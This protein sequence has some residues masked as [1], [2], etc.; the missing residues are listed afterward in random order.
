[1]TPG[2]SKQQVEVLR[3]IEDW[4]GRTTTMPQ[5]VAWR[6]ILDKMDHAYGGAGATNIPSN[7]W[8]KEQAVRR[9]L[10]SLENR[11]VVELR[12]YR[13]YWVDGR[14]VGNK[15]VQG[16]WHILDDDQYYYPGEDRTMIG[17]VLTEA[18]WALMD[19]INNE[20]LESPA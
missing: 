18:G 16:S 8:N 17:A 2:I 14:T 10:R 12:R 4:T 15:Y 6:D 13:Y 20:P 5:A 1:M 19:R 9:A 11:G 7:A 3:V